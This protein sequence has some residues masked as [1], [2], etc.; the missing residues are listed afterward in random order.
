[1]EARIAFRFML[2]ALSLSLVSVEA[3]AISSYNAE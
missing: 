1:M 3:Q 2:I